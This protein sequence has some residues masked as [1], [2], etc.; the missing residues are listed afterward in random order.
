MTGIS[1][2]QAARDL[3]VNPETYSDHDRAR[4]ADNDRADHQHPV[5]QYRLDQCLE[6]CC[7]EHCCVEQW[8]TRPRN[9]LRIR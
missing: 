2:A 3:G 1:I 9:I 4:H 7:L 8:C 5:D 6:H